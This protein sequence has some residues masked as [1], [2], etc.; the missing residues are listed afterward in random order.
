MTASDGSR[1]RRRWPWFVGVVVSLLVLATAGVW[2]TIVLIEGQGGSTRGGQAS[3]VGLGIGG[4]LVALA[5]L[6]VSIMQLRHAHQA[7]PLD[8]ARQRIPSGAR[9]RQ[10]VTAS[11]PGAIAQ[12]VIGGDIHNRFERPDLRARP[13]SSAEELPR[14]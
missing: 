14:T 2:L 9:I 6:V 12:G 13:G 11:V 4:L 10:D 3:G 7:T 8:G 1:T 5:S